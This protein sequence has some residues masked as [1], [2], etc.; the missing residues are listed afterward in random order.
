[1]FVVSPP[2]TSLHTI[3]LEGDDMFCMCTVGR[4]MYVDNEN[5]LSLITESTCISLPCFIVMYDTVQLQ[6]RESVQTIVKRVWWCGVR[7]RRVSF[8]ERRDY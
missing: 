1:M 6:T 3:F 5:V 2:R 7:V 4:G 8:F